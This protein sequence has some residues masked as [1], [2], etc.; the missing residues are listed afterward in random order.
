MIGGRLRVASYV[1][2]AYG[3]G[4]ALDDIYKRCDDVDRAYNGSENDLK[5]VV[6]KYNVA[7][8]YAGREEQRYYPKCITKFDSVAW[9]E[10]VYN[11]SLRIYKVAF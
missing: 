6:E 4:I 11:G 10:P 1:N 3:H 8:I 9:L 7:Y 2:W 5:Q